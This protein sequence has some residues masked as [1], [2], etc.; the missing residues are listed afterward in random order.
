MNRYYEQVSI[1]LCKVV[2]KLFLNLWLRFFFSRCT[3]ISL[4]FLLSPMR[5]FH[6]WGIFRPS[7]GDLT[8]VLSYLGA[9]LGAF[10]DGFG[11]SW[12]MCG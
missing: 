7:W 8:A 6:F 4:S 1:V 12:Y 10:R 5:A 3:Y 11:M 9:L 2:Y